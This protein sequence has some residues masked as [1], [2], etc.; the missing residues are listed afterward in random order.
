M[1]HLYMFASILLVSQM[2]QTYDYIGSH[3][4]LELQQA[5]Q[6]PTPHLTTRNSL[7]AEL[8]HNAVVAEIGVAQGEFSVDILA[9]TNPSQLYLIDCWEEQSQAVY[10]T[11]LNNVGTALQN[12]RYNYVK[13]KFAAN[14]EVKVIRAY[15]PDIAQAFPDQ[16]FD[17]IFLDANHTYDAVKEDLETWLPKIKTGGYLA[18]HDYI[19][20]E[21]L[22]PVGFLFGV[23]PAVN[24][25]C[26]NHGF[27]ISLL[28]T[29]TWSSYAI[30]I[31]R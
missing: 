14:K 27:T 31:T 20:A 5:I 26:K 30:K 1:K 4:P 18:G 23:V 22:K 10:P 12:S 15:T 2:A 21:A 19:T 13:Q 8:P 17:W 11:D 25:F 7:I 29:D 28:S 3:L 6:S 16:F 9:I 24:E